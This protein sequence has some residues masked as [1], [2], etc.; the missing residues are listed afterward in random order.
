M[1]WS[2]LASRAGWPFTAPST[3]APEPEP[4]Q[5]RVG[6]PDRGT[7]A[8]VKAGRKAARRGRRR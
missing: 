7:R 5:P 2:M 1:F 4:A 8:Q 3:P 6:R